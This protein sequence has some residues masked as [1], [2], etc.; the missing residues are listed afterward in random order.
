MVYV[1]LGSSYHSGVC[2]SVLSSDFFLT[3]GFN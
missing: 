2:L 3:F 1:S